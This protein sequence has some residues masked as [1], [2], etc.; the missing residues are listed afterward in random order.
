MKMLQGLLT[1]A[2][3]ALALAGA[4]AQADTLWN[5]TYSGSGVSAS[6]SF[7]TVG[8]GSTPS[9]VEWITGTYTDATIHDGALTLIPATVPGQNVTA[10]GFY[11]Y[12]NLFGGNPRLDSDG[13]MFLAGSQEVNLYLDSSLGMTS[14]TNHGAG[15]DTTPVTF[16]ATAAT[17]AVPE[18][19]TF[20]M[21]LAGLGMFGVV[22]RR[23]AG[24]R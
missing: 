14:V 3:S 9:A 20:A 21:M 7:A 1:V 6:G 8:D 23:R 15:F 17:A 5:F 2:V 22:S 12:D 16:S 13:L 10:D 4:P 11:T 19:G 24:K 18:P